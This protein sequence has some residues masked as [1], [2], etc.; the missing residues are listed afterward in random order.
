MIAII[1]A[2]L[3]VNK[4]A[5]FLS[6]NL[7]GMSLILNILWSGMMLISVIAT[8]FSGWDYLKNGK[9]LLKD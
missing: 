6:G 9:D 2:F 5:E 7:D 3:D 8:V 1:L 4:F